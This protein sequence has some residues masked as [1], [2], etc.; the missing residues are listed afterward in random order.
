MPP[1]GVCL[2]IMRE[3]QEGHG[4]GTLQNPEKFLGQDYELL[5]QYYLIRGRSNWFQ[6]LICLL[7]KYHDLILPR[8]NWFWRFGK[9]VDVVIDDKLPTFKGK[10]IFVHPKTS[11]PTMSPRP[12]NEFWPALLEKAYAKVCG[13]YED[14]H[15][16]SV[17][18]ALMDF[19]GGVH[20]TVQLSS[21]LTG[22]WDLIGRAAKFNSLMGCGTPGQADFNQTLPNGLVEG[23]AYTVTGVTEVRSQGKP[24]QLVRLFNPWGDTEWTGDWSDRSPMWETVSPEEHAMYR[25]NINDGEFWMSVEDFCKTF[26]NLDICSLSPGFLDASSDSQWTSVRHEGRWLAGTS[27]GGCLTTNTFWTNPQFRAKVIAGSDQT[28]GPNMLV[29]LMQKPDKRNRRLVRKLHIGLSIFEVP[30]ELKGSRGTFPASFFDNRPPVA[31]TKNMYDS[32]EVMEFFRLEPGE[33]LIVPY[34]SSPNETASFVVTILSKMETQTEDTLSFS[35][36]LGEMNITNRQN[37]VPYFRQWSDQYTDINAEQLQKLLNAKVIRDVESTGSFSLDACQSI[38]AIMD[39]SVTG[40]LRAT[41]L[42][43]LLDEINLFKDI[44]F[45]VD[46]NRDGILSVKELQHAVEDTGLRVSDGLLKLMTMRYGDASGKITLERFICLALRLDCMTSKACGSYEDMISGNVSEA[47][48]DFTGGV[49]MKVTLRSTLTGL[50]DLIDGADK[51]NSLMGCSTAGKADF[52]QTLPNGLVEGH[53]YTVTGVTEVRS[54]GK[55][56]QLVRL[57][58]PWGDT[59]W[60]GDWSDRSPMWET[61]SPEERE[62]YHKNINNG[63]FWM[64][65]EDFHQTFSNL[66][67][68]SLSPGLLD[69]SS[70]SQWTSVRHERRLLA[71]TYLEPVGH[72]MTGMFVSLMQK[73]IRGTENSSENLILVSVLVFSIFEFRGSRETRQA[74]FFANRSPVAYTKDMKS[75]REVMEFFRLE[76]GEYLIVPYTSSPNQTA[77]FLVTILSKTETQTE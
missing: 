29:S 40:T 22:L 72:L 47:L 69:G 49:H 50:W 67:I 77:S 7:T 34:T 10:L 73:P 61:V 8:D 5:Q 68:C 62:R 18:E 15:T 4:V 1:P 36:D 26:S 3:R 43:R 56:I 20:M 6:I 38:V 24:I 37:S 55:P 14:M 76:P 66:D 19:T 54:Q 65:V 27:A 60:T 9:W 45:R 63:K 46:S 57:F 21:S 31:Y 39:L 17:S 41:E 74:S 70:D 42:S 25:K 30:P 48:M 64:S 16:G 59:E 71:G 51:F 52:N 53:A 58:N 32:R 2:N 35:M 28:Q 44:F 33:Y 12:Q 13:S 11:N 23:H 75:C